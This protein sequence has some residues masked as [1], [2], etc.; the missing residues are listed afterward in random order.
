LVK[1]KYSR[2]SYDIFFIK[3][4]L[5]TILDKGDAFHINHILRFFTFTPWQQMSH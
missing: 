5:D 3:L 1:S 2:P 4:I